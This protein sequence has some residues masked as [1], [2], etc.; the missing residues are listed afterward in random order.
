MPDILKNLQRQRVKIL[1]LAAAIYPVAA[2]A[3]IQSNPSSATNSLY[4]S[5]T[6][7][8]AVTTILPLSLDD[9]IRRGLQH[10]LQTVL[11]AQDQRAASG[12]GL[13][14]INYLLPTIT[15]QA[16]RSRNQINLEAEGFRSSVLG[17]F[18]PGFLPPSAIAN[19]QPLVTVNVVSAQ[20]SLKQTLFDL[21]S[22]EL[23]RAAKQEIHAVDFAFQSA[24][25][26]VIQTVGDS[27]L[28]ALADA[29]N[30]TNAKS[31]LATNEEILRQ[32]TLEHQAGT[33]AKLDELRA[34]VQYQQQ[35]QV[36]IAQQNAFEKAKVVLNREIGL[37]ADQSIQ[38]TDETPYA[39]LEVMPLDQALQVAYANRQE[40]LR[41]QAK[42]RSAKLQSRAA[43]FERVPTLKFDGNYGATGT[44]G[45]IYHGTFMAQGTLNIPLFQEAKFRGDRDVADA[46]TSTAMSQLADYRSEIEAQV[47]DSMLDAAANEQLVNVARS[48]VDLAH[49]SFDDA[50]E[51]FKNGI[52]DDLPVVQAQASLA[53]AQ[54]QLVNS[55]YQ[56]DRSKL[57]LARSVGI[58]DR[59][60]RAYLG[61]SNQ[62]AA[63][64]GFHDL[65]G[66][67]LTPTE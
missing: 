21:K 41:L 11:A 7:T 37:P 46:A 51:R 17:S 66:S 26:A 62:A 43:R 42:L 19:F 24:R 6:T 14:A 12:E 9:A 53:A 40:Y 50:T 3:Q 35:E 13:E 45:G 39:E 55:L 47:R 30:V 56:Y 22:L 28:L 60:Y 64:S 16:Q 31:L 5:V 67:S 10:N 2:L 15:W 44:V 54:T 8:Q 49:S 25:G 20:A 23:Y 36:V 58:I 33:A 29:A 65:Y 38:L 59:Q 34:R 1:L 61:T 57:A 4:G 52:D 32:A 48:N 27:Y 18:P 63:S